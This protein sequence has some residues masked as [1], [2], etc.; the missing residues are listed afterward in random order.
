MEIERLKIPNYKH[1]GFI[2]IYLSVLLCIVQEIYK[3]AH[4]VHSLIY[5]LAD[6]VVFFFF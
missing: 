6:S 3:I 1:N 2:S 4:L 5:I